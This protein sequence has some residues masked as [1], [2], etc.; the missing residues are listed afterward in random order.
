MKKA[1]ILVLSISTITGFAQSQSYSLKE[2]QDYALKNAYSV[3]GKELEYKKA[4]KQILETAAIG[5][6]QINFSADY[7]Y[8]SQIAATP[9]PDGFLGPEDGQPDLAKFGV[10]HQTVAVLSGSQLIFDAS[11]IVAL[12]ATRVVKDIASLNIEKAKIDIRADVAKAYYL[13]LVSSETEKIVSG[14][15]E[16]LKKNL[17]EMREFYKNGLVEEQDVDQ[18]E[19]LLNTQ[20]S[21]LQNAQRQSD[22]ALKMLKFQMGMDINTEMSLK[23]KLESLMNDESEG[24][25]LQNFNLDTHIDFRI[26]E[27]QK[28][29]ASLQL[30][31]QRNTLF[32]KLSAFAR[33]TES[34]FSN[35][36][37]NAFNFNTFWVPGTSLGLSLNWSLFTGLGRTA[38]I[39]QARIDLDRLDIATASTKSG[40]EMSY[41]RAKSDYKFAL[42]NYNTQKRNIELSERIRNKT[43]IKYK[44]GISSSLDLTQAENQYLQAQGSYIQSI[45]NLLNSKEEFSRT[46]G[47]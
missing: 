4:K 14:N 19:L 1:L 38:R 23:D 26:L 36:E 37:F 10:E 30:A 28:K 35:T 5:L 33:H 12:Q 8:N 7:T 42:D 43:R 47:K 44:E 20:E 22:L 15:V 32:P 6:P 40:L 39:Q 24:E 34:N 11:Y 17:F 13:V 46:L 9:L 31:N 16:S 3:V 18:L 21:S 45:L 2:A 41:F 27:S 29:A 25:A